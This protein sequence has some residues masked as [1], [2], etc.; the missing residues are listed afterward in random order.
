MVI[1]CNTASAYAYDAIKTKYGNSID[2]VN[3]IDP[4]VELVSSNSSYQ[5]VA[6]IGTKGTISSN[7][8]QNK[9]LKLVY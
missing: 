9:I 2:I 1:A 6:V 7:I 5:N 3:V 4:M 8:Y